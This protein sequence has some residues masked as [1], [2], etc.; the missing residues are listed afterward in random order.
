MSTARRDRAE[1]Q[2]RP[3]E[4]AQLLRRAIRSG[5]IT[6]GQSL[7]QEE[8]A[9]RFGVSRGPL[10]EALR[11]L[12]GEGLVTITPG[13][14]A[15]VTSLDPGEITELYDLRILLETD[16][17]AAIASRAQAG[18]VT[19]LDEMAGR[20]DDAITAAEQDRWSELNYRFHH[21]MYELAAR[22]HSLRIV[23]QLLSLVEPYSRAF[24][25]GMNAYERV[26]AEHHG[27]VTALADQDAGALARLIAC[28]LRGAKHGLVEQLAS[29]AQSRD[30]LDSLRGLTGTA[31]SRTAMRPES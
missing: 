19:E 29:S 10:R 16:L 7:I 13:Y 5:V 25:H 15:V 20:M 23:T 6:P 3:E 17:A 26:Q 18:D 11:L 2:P 24:V 4:I 28:H 22:P 21:R 14:G 9:A 8:L 31:R 1:P 12:A 27:M 30:M